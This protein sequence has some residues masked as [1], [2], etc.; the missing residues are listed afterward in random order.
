MIEEITGKEFDSFSLNH[1][2]SNYHESSNY[3][4]LMSK[5]GYDRV[6]LGYK[7][8]NK[9]IAATILL[10]KKINHIFKYA[11]APKGF[12]INYKDKKLLNDF[13]NEIKNY[14]KNN[15]I[16][17]IKINPEIPIF[18][19]NKNFKRRKLS[20]FEI[21]ETLINLG[22]IK[23]KD[24]L[25]FESMLP[26]FNGII[27]LS[28]YNIKNINKT[29]RNKIHNAERKGLEI[30]VYQENKIKDLF[31]FIEKKKT[32]RNINYYK[33]Y[34]NIFNEDNMADIF[35]VKINYNKYLENSKNVYEDE[36]E[37][38]KKITE[39][40]FKN[41]TNDNIARKMSSDT[42]LRSYKNDVINATYGST[43]DPKSCSYCNKW[44]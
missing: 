20:N 6:Y 23:L 9:I 12:L 7:K 30:E 18:I 38:N 5:Y 43:R 3:A 1:E 26:R 24:N 19:Y 31:P 17:F 4:T 10:T 36:L 16:I 41:N 15:K 40:L 37:N 32:R 28:E 39:K 14:A 11:Y 25:Y 21:V 42:K 35:L 44:L 34:F 27:D 22:Y 29:N 13:T 33:N 8:N 2:L